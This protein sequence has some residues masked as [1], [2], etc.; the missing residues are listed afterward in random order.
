M[1]I[2]FVNNKIK[3]KDRLLVETARQVCPPKVWRDKGAKSKTRQKQRH[4]V[5]ERLKKLALTQIDKKEEAKNW[6]EY[7][8]ETSR[9]G[10]REVEE[11]KKETK[12]W[13]TRR[14]NK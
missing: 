8:K 6:V 9:W 2:E 12:K 11:E 10:K 13:Q 3:E 4:E 7:I 1:T 5:L 14:L